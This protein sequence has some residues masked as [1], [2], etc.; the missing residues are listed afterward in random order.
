MINDTN[1]Q[2][3]MLYQTLLALV[4]E[5]PQLKQAMA[6]GPLGEVI[7]VHDRL[8]STLMVIRTVAHDLAELESD[9]NRAM[10]LLLLDEQMTC[11]ILRLT[12]LPASA[13]VAMAPAGDFNQKAGACEQ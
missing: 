1:D 6:Y 8:V 4:G 13:Q 10:A 2:K 9:N 5:V 7:D 3:T 11:E 12:Q